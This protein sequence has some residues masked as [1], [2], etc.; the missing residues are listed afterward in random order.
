V[1]EGIVYSS[2]GDFIAPYN[3]RNIMAVLYYNADFVVYLKRQLL[4]PG[5]IRIN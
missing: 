3:K 1:V 4:P 2:L 5:D